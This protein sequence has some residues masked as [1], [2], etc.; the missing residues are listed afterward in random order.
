MSKGIH[1]ET[2]FY[3]KTSNVFINSRKLVKEN[4]KENKQIE[5][6]FGIFDFL[7]AKVQQKR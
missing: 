5:N 4:K 6:Q 3:R 7:R 2:I 1:N